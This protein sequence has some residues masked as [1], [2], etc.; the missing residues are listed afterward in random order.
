MAV[1]VTMKI[2]IR[3]EGDGEIERKGTGPRWR[4]RNKNAKVEGPPRYTVTDA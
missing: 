1:V 2:V 4:T 3:W